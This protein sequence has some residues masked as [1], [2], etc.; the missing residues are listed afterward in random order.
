MTASTSG[1]SAV[2]PRRITF[3][4]R[5]VRRPGA[6][7]AGMILVRLSLVAAALLLCRPVQAM[8]ACPSSAWRL[9]L[10]TPAVKWPDPALTNDARLLHGMA[11][12][13]FEH[14]PREEATDALL[15]AAAEKYLRLTEDAEQTLARQEARF[16]LGI[17][18]AHHA[19]DYEWDDRKADIALAHFIALTQPGLMGRA[20][21]QVRALRLRQARKWAYISRHTLLNAR[22]M[23]RPGWSGTSQRVRCFIAAYPGYATDADVRRDLAWLS[24]RARD[25]IHDYAADPRYGL[26]GMRLLLS[27]LDAYLAGSAAP[28]DRW[29]VTEDLDPAA[30]D[31]PDNCYRRPSRIPGPEAFDFDFSPEGDARRQ[32]IAKARRRV[33]AVLDETLP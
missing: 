19:P 12:E 18:Y 14:C 11:R 5:P 3:R 8:P 20:A 15:T 23:G 21:D 32:A 29:P 26:D 22:N 25:F 2:A 27:E 31:A 6:I 1:Y 9:G 24:G 17:V 13:L 16:W 33:Q 10:W 30:P 28:A 4:L 7:L